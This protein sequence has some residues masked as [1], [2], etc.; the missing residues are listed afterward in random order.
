MLKGS[1]VVNTLQP[2]CSVPYLRSQ[3]SHLTEERHL[4]NTLQVLD[5]RQTTVFKRAVDEKYQLKLKVRPPDGHWAL[6]RGSM[7]C[8]W[9]RRSGLH[10]GLQSQMARASWPEPACPGGHNPSSGKAMCGTSCVTRCPPAC[11]QH[12]SALY[13][14]A[15]AFGLCQDSLAAAVHI[16]CQVLVQLGTAMRSL[17]GVPSCPQARRT[18]GLQKGPLYIPH[19]TVLHWMGYWP[20]LLRFLPALNVLAAVGGPLAE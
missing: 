10:V 14:R 18:L 7:P 5:D 16:A 2:G 17:C 9:R 4:S 15:A 20:P 13:I 19:Y 11:W 12:A 8:A 3:T 6:Q 1:E